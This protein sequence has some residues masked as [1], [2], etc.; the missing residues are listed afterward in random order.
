M[1]AS[2]DNHA[3]AYCEA[4]RALQRVL[5]ESRSQWN[6]TA[7]QAFDRRHVDRIVKDGKR[8]ESDLI[9]LAADLTAAVRASDSVG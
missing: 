9:R 8:T 4:L 7:R 6:D 3:A 5:E 2:I 1:N